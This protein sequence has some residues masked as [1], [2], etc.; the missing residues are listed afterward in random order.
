[1]IFTQEECDKI[2]SIILSPENQIWKD[3]L[4]LFI[5]N[6]E[7]LENNTIKMSS[8]SLDSVDELENVIFYKIEKFEDNNDTNLFNIAKTVVKFVIELEEFFDTDLEKSCPEVRIL[9]NM[10]IK[11]DSKIITQKSFKKIRD[12]VEKQLAIEISTTH[13]P[14]TI[15]ALNSVINAT[16]EN[17]KSAAF[18]SIKE[19]VNTW[20]PYFIQEYSNFGHEDKDLIIK[21]LKFTFLNSIIPHLS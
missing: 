10:I 9:Y 1:M 17:F 21:A 13:N 6:Q 20:I 14:S 18:H 7:D 5:N 16:D 3:V 19:S 15:T 11:M 8:V 12:I 4:Y 2:M